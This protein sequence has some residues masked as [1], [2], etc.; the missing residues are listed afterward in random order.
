MVSF[1]AAKHVST[2]KH[3]YI[4]GSTSVHSYLG[5]FQYLISFTDEFSRKVWIYFMKRK[6]EAF[7][8]FVEWKKW[9]NCRKERR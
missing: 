1:E 3:E 9:W 4:W 5:S 2:E 7:G 8:K 6:D